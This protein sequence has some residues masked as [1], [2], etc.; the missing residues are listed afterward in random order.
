M[1]MFHAAFMMAGSLLSATNAPVPDEAAAQAQPVV[2]AFYTAVVA[3]GRRPSFRP[4]VKLATSPGATRYD[5]RERAVV[6]VPYDFLGP[7]R[8]AAM[9]RFAS[10]GTLGL[11]GREQYVEVFNTLLVAHE[12]GHW[13]QEISRRPLTRWQAEYEANRMMVAFWRDHPGAVSSELRL[14]NFV[15]QRSPVAD[16]VPAGTAVGEAEY[17]NAN[18]ASIETD[19][20]RYSLYQKKMVRL[21]TAEQPAPS[22]CQTV[23]VAWP[24]E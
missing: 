14:A 9:E 11:S 22:F 17:F 8:R 2:D 20:I 1:N 19:P 16:L 3:C 15:A 4:I 18:I 5:P 23:K 7:G 12:L 13:L 10:I 24:H 6:I 21:A